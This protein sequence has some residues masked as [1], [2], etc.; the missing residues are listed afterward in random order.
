MT[1]FQKYIKSLKLVD[2][3]QVTEHSLRFLL[4][5]LLEELLNRKIDILHE[6]KREGKFGSPDFKISDNKGIVGYVETK[7]IDDNL[8]KIL[9]SEQIKKYSELS[10]NILLTNYLEFIWLRNGKVELRNSLCFFSDLHDK[11]FQITDEKEKTVENII[12]Q[13]LKE[14]P[15]GINNAK[16]LSTALAKRT[17]TLKDFLQ[18]T[19]QD[20]EDNHQQTVLMS[21]LDSFRKNI[22]AEL[23]IS[24]FA[25]AFAQMLSYGLFLAKLNADTKEIT[26]Y[27]VAEHIPQSFHL[28]KELVGFLN[29]LNDK[30]YAN[31]RWIVEEIINLLNNIDLRAIQESLSF[32]KNKNPNKETIADPYLYFYEDFLG[33]YDKQLRKSKGVYYTP[34]EIVSFIVR[35]TNDL[36]K[37]NFKISDGFANKKQITVLDFATGTGTFILEIIKQI[38]EEIPQNSTK[39]EG[40]IKEHI[41]K[42]IYGF[43]YLIAPYTI[44]HLKLSQFLKDNDYTLQD[45][46]RLQIYLTNTLVPLKTEYNAY[47]QALSEEGITAQKIKEK[48]I[49]IITGNPPYSVSSLNKSVHIDNIMQRYKE[50]MPEKNIQSLSDDYIK[51]IRFAHRKIE[52]EGKGIIAIITNNS[53]LS[54]IIHRKMREEII[55]DFDKIYIINLH[56][57]SL[58]KEGDENIFDIRVGVSILLLIKTEK[59]QKQKEVLY[60]STKDNELITRKEKYTFFKTINL[61]DLSL[62]KLIPQ[63]PNFWFLPK[64]LTEQK[65]WETFLSIEDIF[66]KSSSGVKTHRD[67]FLVNHNKNL[68]QTSINDFYN[69]DYSISERLRKFELK[70]TRDWHI[71]TALKNKFDASLTKDYS[72]RVFDHH[73]IHYDLN[74][75]ER[76]TNRNDIMQNFIQKNDN[77]GLVCTRLLSSDYFTHA[78]VTNKITDMCYISN[79]GS[80][81]NYIF[82]LFVDSIEKEQKTIQFEGENG[83]KANFTEMFK[84]FIINQY[85]NEIRNP[86]AI[87]NYIYAIL[88]SPAYREKYNEFLKIGFPK[89]PFIKDKSTF[90]KL[91]KIGEQLILVHLQK[92]IPNYRIGQPIGKGTNEVTKIVHANNKLYYNEIQYFDNVTDEIFDFKIGSFQILDKYLKSR[93]NKKL[94]FDEIDTFEIIIKSIQFTIDKMKEINKLTNKWI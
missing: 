76:G 82:P 39:R 20:Q 92:E 86:I 14:N 63:A 89:I 49:L 23:R 21:L 19:L 9:K 48:P 38:F 60:F 1:P 68:L 37:E 15:T 74:L 54:G 64:D 7:K 73:Y 58:K 4:Q 71:D 67:H 83:W 31:T 16:D 5:T 53:Y 34:P 41:L 18:E 91:A 57:N 25:D 70:N 17:R 80:E 33:Q 62:I 50:G 6:G 94:D 26:L 11:K 90:Y 79:K 55:K 81:A 13:F 24:E 30:L 88:Y 28:I 3:S 2:F 85:D 87:L 65:Q 27:T 46:E 44:A 12:N 42:N 40:I 29:K 51:F 59:P 61:N 75:I 36:L 56:G 45:D 66:I 69:G 52:I 93:K 22:A 72:Y 84:E 77:L 35:S 47:V 10:N 78:F 8:D 32:N 43:E